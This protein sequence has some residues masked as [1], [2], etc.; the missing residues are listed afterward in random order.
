MRLGSVILRSSLLLATCAFA[1]QAQE[2][3][4]SNIASTPSATDKIGR[5]VRIVSISFS[6]KP[7]E[8]IAKIVDQEGAGGTDLIAL[9]ETWR[10]QTNP[11]TLDG[12]TV[13]AMAA[14][15]AKHRT[16]IVCPIDR[17]DGARRLNSAVLIDR[18]GKVVCVY[19]KVF[20]YWSEYDLKPPVDP[21]REAPVYQADFGKIGM[22]ICFDANFAEVWKRMAD[23]GAELIIWPSAYSAGTTLQT[24]A[25]ANHFHIVT[26]TWTKDC[27]VYDIT[28]EEIHYSK[29]PDINIARI[30]LDLDRGIYHQNFNIEKRDKLLKEHAQDVVQEK[31]MDR[32]QWFVLKAKRPGVSARELA[33]KY[34]MEELRDYID[35]S[36][37]EIDK[38]RGWPFG[39]K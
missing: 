6:G 33:K 4:R 21:G 15:A 8:L 5:A 28:G 35:R 30:T 10:G 14:V 23:Q 39:T 24:H 20:P 19:D 27:I 32:E 22:A 9:P 31:W 12:P 25:L 34:G 26:A 38:K 18:N 16:Y 2:A 37:R 3:P 7:L 29:S 11:E 1:L 36:R 17:K 13:K